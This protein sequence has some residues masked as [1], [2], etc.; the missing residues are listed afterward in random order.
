MHPETDN[1]DIVLICFLGNPG[2]KYSKTRHSIG[3]I[4]AEKIAAAFNFPQFSYCRKIKGY[5]SAGMISERKTVLLKP[6]T[7][8]NRSGVA[9]AKALELFA[10]GIDNLIVVHD[11]VDIKFGSH[12]IKTK[13]GSGGHNGLRSI[14]GEIGTD[15]FVRIRIG[16]GKPVPEMDLADYVLSNF[17]DGELS[18]IDNSLSSKW[19]EIIL[20]IVNEGAEEAMNTFNR[21]NG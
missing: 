13:G 19:G 12:R 17:F 15:K 3:F 14:E 5:V 18:F 2:E 9:V 20:K 4:F 21:R 8:M 16:I 6:D 7:Y 1:S 11:D 10:V